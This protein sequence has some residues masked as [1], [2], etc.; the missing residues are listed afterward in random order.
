M[1]KNYLFFNLIKN[2]NI[3]FKSKEELLNLHKKSLQLESNLKLRKN[4]EYEYNKIKLEEI[5]ENI[6]EMKF[7]K[8]FMHKRN[9][10]ILEEIQSNDFK[11]L[12]FGSLS[13]QYLSN[14]KSKKKKYQN[15]LDYM[16]P[17]IKSEFNTNVFFQN[18]I[19]NEEIQNELNKY[20]QNMNK[21]IYYEELLKTNDRL[22]K[23]IKYL[24]NK[25]NL[26]TLEIQEKEKR[27]LEN[28]EIKD[29]NFNKNININYNKIINNDN[30]NN[31]K[32]RIN[33]NYINENIKLINKNVL[34]SGIKYPQY[35]LNMN[36]KFG[37]IDEINKKKIDKINEKI[38]NEY[39]QKNL[40]KEISESIYSSLDDIR[41]QIINPNNQIN[42][43]NFHGTL[44]QNF[45]NNNKIKC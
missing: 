19:F 37:I 1:S 11:S 5:N 23:E 44:N 12:E 25:N 24:K 28:K 16:Q 35:K 38:R 18:N 27:F 42:N 26:L 7:Q 20:K 8:K 6:D 39:Y 41:K 29:N 22:A 3:D 36:H 13:N 31:N 10:E 45:E 2:S 4:I 15:Y 33:N 34:N 30:I 14:I 17:K 40:E 21:N 32:D 9:E 43:D